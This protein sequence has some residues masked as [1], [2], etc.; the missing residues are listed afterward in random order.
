LLF[1]CSK[2]TIKFT[3]H[4][5]SSTEFHFTSFNWL[6]EFA[7]H[8]ELWLFP[9]S[10]SALESSCSISL[11]IAALSPEALDS[12]SASSIVPMTD[13]NWILS[14]FECHFIDFGTL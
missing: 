10:G 8:S 9:Y 6:W 7:R 1:I 13:L 3:N 11:F 4:F 12:V 14:N 2:S 5:E